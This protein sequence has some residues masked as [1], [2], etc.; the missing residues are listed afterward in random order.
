MRRLLANWNCH[1][2]HTTFKSE[3]IG[4]GGR[5]NWSWAGELAGLRKGWRWR[6]VEGGGA[7][8]QCMYVHNITFLIDSK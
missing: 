6:V 8:L 1:K 7:R 4:G 2:S 3:G 5:G